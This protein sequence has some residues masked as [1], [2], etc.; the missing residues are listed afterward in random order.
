MAVNGGGELGRG[1][2]A[3]L[4]R[5]IDNA[6]IIRVVCGFEHIARARSVRAVGQCKRFGADGDGGDLAHLGHGDG[7]RGACRAFDIDGSG[8]WQLLIVCPTDHA[9][10]ADGGGVGSA[11][12]YNA[13]DFRLLDMKRLFVLGLA[14]VADGKIKCHSPPP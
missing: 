14:E 7:G 3:Q 11:H 9:L 12:V 4:F 13:L 6:V 2:S 8:V 10:F 5:V 1:F